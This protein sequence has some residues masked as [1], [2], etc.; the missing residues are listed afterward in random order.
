MCV[1][2]SPFPSHSPHPSPSDFIRL[3]P[4]PSALTPL[5][6]AQA[7]KGAEDKLTKD[8][9]ECFASFDRDKDGKISTKELGAV[10]RSLG[11]SPTAAELKTYAA[12]VDKGNKGTIELKDV[13]AIVAKKIKDKL[14]EDQLKK[15]FKVFDK[16]GN[17]FVDADELRHALTSLGEK[18]TQEEV[19]EMVKEIKVD[20]DGQ[21]N[22]DELVSQ[23]LS[24][25]RTS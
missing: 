24:L 22:Y 12:E 7:A 16:E 8:V 15:A 25:A 14:A 20:A 19:D 17:G 2:P 1:A 9:K 6:P 5:T 4:C 11:L 21:F 3:T 13:Q 10:L 23:L 18:F